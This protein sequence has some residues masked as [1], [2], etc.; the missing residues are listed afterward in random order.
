MKRDPTSRPQSKKSEEHGHPI[1]ALYAKAAVPSMH[2]S[3]L[4]RPVVAL[5]TLSLRL[6]DWFHSANHHH[7]ANHRARRWPSRVLHLSPAAAIG[8]CWP[9]SSSSS[10]TTPL[11]HRARSWTDEGSVHQSGASPSGTH[12]RTSTWPQQTEDQRFTI[13]FTLFILISFSF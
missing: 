13:L 4:S 12:G 3:T 7:S 9:C 6:A 11:R 10:F 5:R 2:S 1:L 8:L